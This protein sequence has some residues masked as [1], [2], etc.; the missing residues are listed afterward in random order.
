MGSDATHAACRRASGGRTQPL[1]RQCRSCHT[2]GGDRGVYTLPSLTNQGGFDA[3]AQLGTAHPLGPGQD[4]PCGG[5]AAHRKLG[6][7]AS[8]GMAI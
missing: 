7:E 5:R 6:D 3:G 8:V 1:A 2:G 4:S